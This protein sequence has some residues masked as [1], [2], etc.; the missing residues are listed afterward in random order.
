ML[1]LAGDDPQAKSSTLPTHSEVA[2]YDF[3]MPVLFPGNVQDIL[4]LGRLGFE[5]SRYSGLWVGFKIVTNVADEVGTAEVGP[6]RVRGRGSGFRLRG[7]AVGA[8]PDPGAAAA[9]HA[10]GR[11]RD[12]LRAP[13]GGPGVRRR[14]RAQPDHGA[15]AGRL[16]RHRR[17]RQDLLRPAPGAGRPGA[18]RRGAPRVTASGSSSSGCSSRWSRGSSA[19]SPAGSRRCS[20][21]RR[22]AASSSCSSARRSTSLPDRP[23]IVGKRDEQPARS[24][25]RPTASSTPT[26]SPAWSP[27]AWTAGSRSTRSGRAWRS[28]RRR[29]SARSSLTLARPPYFCSGCPH[30]RSTVVPE[31]SMAAGGHRLSRPGA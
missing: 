6:D 27:V 13:R 8:A 15:H 29:A 12:R 5:L 21:S 31:G 22:S 16:A 3:Q 19:S 11:A 9:L 23:R 1:A 14:Q 26:R 24:W 7:P 30:N 17:G 10:R 18:R 4:D 25:F 28:S 20:S 2:F